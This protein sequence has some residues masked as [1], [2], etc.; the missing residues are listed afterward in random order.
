VFLAASVFAAP[1]F[2]CRI[3]PS[4]AIPAIDG[5]LVKNFTSDETAVDWAY[6]T[7]PTHRYGHG[8]LGDAVEAGALVARNGITSSLCG[9]L[10][11]L[12]VDRVF[13]DIA[14]RISDV[15]GDGRADAVV[16][17]TSV[18]EGAQ[19]AIYGFVSEDGFTTL[20][21]LAATPHIGRPYRWLAPAGIAD[22]DGDGQNDVAYVE[23]PHIGGILRIWTMRDGD[24]V[25]IAS[26][27]GYAN[28]RIGQN[29]ITGGVR[30]CG[31]GPEL[32]LPNADWSQTLVAWLGGGVI[33]AAVLAEDATPETI[34][35]LMECP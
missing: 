21:K 9:D 12:P 7:E 23:T 25:E 13:E 24:L 11:R 34:A 14:P 1:A 17:E 27:P 4:T 18:T 35:R 2:A 32:V 30:D 20:R 19:L 22:F 29:F 15:T 28:H 3:F 6:F 10:Y 26:D 5:S 16:V 33:E 8:V 31:N